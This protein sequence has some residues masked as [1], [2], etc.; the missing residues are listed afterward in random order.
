MD[1]SRKE[2]ITWRELSKLVSLIIPQFE[3]VFDS[4]IM[5]S[6]S[7]VIPGGMISAAA[8]IKEI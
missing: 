3:T 4:I 2:I 7:G 6:P 8:G 1:Q 5:I